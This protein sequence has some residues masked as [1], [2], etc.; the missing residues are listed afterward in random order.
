[1][2]QR[3]YVVTDRETGVDRYVR[4]KSLNGAIRAIANEKFTAKSANTEQLF[5][6]YKGGLEVLDALDDG[7]VDIEDITGAGQ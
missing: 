4:A 6:A 5:Q 1:M 3:I 7:P 2:S